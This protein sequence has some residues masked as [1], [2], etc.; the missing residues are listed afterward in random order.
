MLIR[1]LGVVALACVLGACQKEEEPV[2]Q[3]PVV[4]QSEPAAVLDMASGALV[5]DQS[6]AVQD[7]A[8]ALKD[9]ADVVSQKGVL[10]P[11][12]GSSGK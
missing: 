11:L 2:A 5:V 6:A 10:E 1:L 12:N 8:A 9:A 7:A 3:A 4:A